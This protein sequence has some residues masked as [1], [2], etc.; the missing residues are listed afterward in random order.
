MSCN[1]AVGGLAQG[2]PRARDRRARRRDGPRHRRDRHPVP[3]A[4]HAAAARRSGRRARR[5]TAIV[6]RA[7]MAQELRAETAPHADRG[8]WSRSSC[9]IRRASEPPA[10]SSA[11]ACARRR[12]ATT[13]ARS[14]AARRPDA[15]H[16][17]ERPDALRPAQVV[18]GP[19]RRARRA[20]A[21]R[22]RSRARGLRAR[23]AQDR[24][25]AAPRTATRSPGTDSQVA[26]RRRPAAAVLALGRSRRSRTAP[27]AT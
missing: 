10:R 13:A 26:A 8:G 24:H 1:P 16:V 2:T 5:P 3:H 20:P 25:A 23:P 18:G 14:G 6:Y 11:A 9:S 27:S 22:R 21:C 12:A 15:R 7:A 19:P 17:P 4:Q